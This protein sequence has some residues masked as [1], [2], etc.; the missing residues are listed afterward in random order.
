MK[1]SAL[2]CALA[3]ALVGLAALA[4]ADEHE[5]GGR[6]WEGGRGWRAQ[7]QPGWQREGGPP[8]G[9]G[10]HQ[11][12]GQPAQP[13]P[14]AYPQQRFERH[15]PPV[16]V[17]P[18]PAPQYAP[19]PQYLPPPPPPHWNHARGFRPGDALPPEYR[20]RQFIVRDWRSHRLYAPPPGYVW[21][22]PEPGSYLLIGNNGVIANMLVGQ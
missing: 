14:Q 3:A 5:R 8:P 2:A 7:E 20:Q 1:P 12:G 9:R 10:W 21:V 17:T 22:Q 4:H 13:A 15:G 19:P 18:M 16:Y 6:Q 11:Q